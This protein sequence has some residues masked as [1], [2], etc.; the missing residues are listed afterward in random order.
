MSG[1][2]PGLQR[3]YQPSLWKLRILRLLPHGDGLLQRGMH[4]R[5][6]GLAKLRRLRKRLPRGSWLCQRDMLC[7]AVLRGSGILRRLLQ[8]NSG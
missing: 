7:G 2:L 4:L 3:Q 1:G 8:G 5:E 6:F